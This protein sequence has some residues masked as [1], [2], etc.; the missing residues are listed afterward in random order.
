MGNI[1]R[2][3]SLR[4]NVLDQYWCHLYLTL[5]CTILPEIV[6]GVI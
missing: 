5:G 6:E 3:L 2:E 4:T 1:S